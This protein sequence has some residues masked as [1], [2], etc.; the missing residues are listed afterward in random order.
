M[1]RFTADQLAYAASKKAYMGREES[2]EFLKTDEYQ[3][4]RR[5]LVGR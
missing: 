4:Q 5:P 2:I 1:T 3:A